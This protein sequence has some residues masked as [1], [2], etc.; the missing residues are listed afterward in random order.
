MVMCL[1]SLTDQSILP[2]TTT[3]AKTKSKLSAKKAAVLDSAVTLFANR[4]FAST[5]MDAI[6][7]AA[8][9]AKGTVYHYFNS[10]DDLFLAAAERTVAELGE[11]ILEA[12]ACVEEPVAV[13]RTACRAVARYSQKHP[14][15]VELFVQ[16]RAV[17][18]DKS[19]L[20]LL[21]AGRDEVQPFFVDV[22]RRGIETGVFRDVDPEE[23][24][25][26]ISN[27]LYGLVV[28]SFLEGAAEKLIARADA[29]IKFILDGLLAVDAEE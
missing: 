14:E 10:K 28:S 18:R 6:A 15:A 22:V 7:A 16:Q 29:Q 5:E 27:L 12:I 19:P 2:Q 1:L 21:I 24:V 25:R 11:F 13:I 20:I 8:G 3:M 9:V 17:F 23:A 4:G 26:A